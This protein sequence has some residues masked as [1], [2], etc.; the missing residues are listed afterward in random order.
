MGKRHLIKRFD[1]IGSWYV[2]RRDEGW[3]VVN[4]KPSEYWTSPSTTLSYKI[5]EKWHRLPPSVQTAIKVRLCM[6]RATTNGQ[7]G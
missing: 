2:E 6:G 3:Y 5:P 4:E 1:F 7:R